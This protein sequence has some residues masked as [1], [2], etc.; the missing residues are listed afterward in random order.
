MSATMGANARNCSPERRCYQDGCE[1]CEALPCHHQASVTGP[2]WE[3]TSQIGTGFRYWSVSAPGVGGLGVFRSAA[4]AL[5]VAAAYR[6][7]AATRRSVLAAR[8]AVRS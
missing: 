6:D 4:P 1:S 5:A 2:H 3:S 7:V 8:A